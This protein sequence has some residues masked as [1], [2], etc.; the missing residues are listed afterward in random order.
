MGRFVIGLKA[1]NR[2]REPLVINNGTIRNEIRCSSCDKVLVSFKYDTKIDVEITC[3]HCR[4][5]HKSI[6]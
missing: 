5:A 2:R 1:G 3:P 6:R 4:I